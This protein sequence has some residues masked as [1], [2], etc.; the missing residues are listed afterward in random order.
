MCC[1]SVGAE[2]LWVSVTVTAIDWGAMA[3][4]ISVVE[5]PR[6]RASQ[7]R[8]FKLKISEADGCPDE[9]LYVRECVHAFAVHA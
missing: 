8:I 3:E 9:Y 1:A 7:S 6:H 5:K 2:L 4:L